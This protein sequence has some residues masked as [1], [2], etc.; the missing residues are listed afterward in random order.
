MVENYRE[1]GKVRQR[2]IATIG[3]L[4]KLYAAGSIDSLIKSLSRFSERLVV[5]NAYEEGAIVSEWEKQWGPSLVFGRL[6]E[7]SS[8]RAIFQ[9]LSIRHRCEFSLERAIFGITLQRIFEP[10][11]DLQGSRWLPRVYTEGFEQLQLQHLYRGLDFLEEHFHEV[12]KRLFY[13][14]RDLFTTELDLVFFDTTS[15]YFE[16][17]GPEGLARRGY[18]K[19]RR[20]DH[21]QVIIGIVMTREGIPLACEI[22]PGNTADLSTVEHIVGILKERFN[23]GR[24]I[25]VCDRGMVSKVNLHLLS[26]KRLPYIVGMKMRRLKEVREKVLSRAGRFS[27]VE[28]NLEVKEVRVGKRRYI[29]CRNP[30]EVIKDQKEREEITRTLREKLLSGESK[31]LIGNSAY[32]SYLSIERGAIQINESAIR[33]AQRFDGKYVLRTNTDLPASEVAKAYK[34]LWQV[35][36]LF[37]QLKDVLDARPIYH[38]RSERVKGH[39]YA[40]FLSLYLVTMLKKKMESKELRVSSWENALN[41]LKEI[42]ATAVKA[43][44]KNFLLR[45]PIAGDAAIVFQAAGVRYPPLCQLS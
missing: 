5:I 36:A 9:D 17:K 18:S 16:G 41:E 7:E 15:L 32:R 45:S 13:R 34:G 3:R 40:S 38:R 19:E 8:L 28:E 14:I 27:E 2:V 33:E 10:G 42:K 24:V 20:P 12:Q 37:R 44:G 23:I 35:E 25:L 31:S 11:S 26:R 39:I 30:E 22:W 4:D 1:N 29:I 43:G 6:W 21:P